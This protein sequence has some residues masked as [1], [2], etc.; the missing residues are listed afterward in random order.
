MSEYLLNK[1][2]ILFNPEVAEVI[3]LN[4]AIV[5]QQINYW[6]NKP[7]AKE[8]DGKR[9]IYNSID[10][11][12]KD[13]FPFW[14]ERTIRRILKKLEDEELIISGRFNK[15]TY[16]QTKWYTINEERLE[17]VMRRDVQN[18]P[19]N[20]DASCVQ[21]DRIRCGQNGRLKS[22]KMDEP[23]PET[24]R[25]YSESTSVDYLSKEK[26]QDSH[27]RKDDLSSKDDLRDKKMEDIQAK[28]LTTKIIDYFVGKHT[29]INNSENKF[30]PPMVTVK[31]SQKLIPIAKKLIQAK[32][33]IVEI[34]QK[35]DIS[36][37][38]EGVDYYFGY[39]VSVLDNFA[40]QELRRQQNES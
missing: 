28:I 2:P 26:G 25:D 35:I 14:S 5:L 22:G 17:A 4:Q 11:W 19:D 24:T 30:K 12:Q 31:E 33:P 13:N 29:E 36:L 3:G 6:I 32:L 18:E 39:M 23:I 21:N 37:V 27:E 40:E 9:W 20:K 8:I 1:R 7:F 15:A 38:K 34:Y 10:Q 16:D